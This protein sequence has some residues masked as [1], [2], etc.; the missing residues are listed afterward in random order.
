LLDDTLSAPLGLSRD[1]V[2]SF[3]T[4]AVWCYAELAV[5][6]RIGGVTSRRWNGYIVAIAASRGF[7]AA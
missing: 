3:V 6:V 1:R 7:I 2:L 5:T 4:E